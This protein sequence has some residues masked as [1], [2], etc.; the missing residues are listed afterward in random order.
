ML[1][2]CLLSGARFA[3]EVARAAW[4]SG[5]SVRAAVCAGEGAIFEDAS[6]QQSFATPASARAAQLLSRLRK[7]A[8]SALAIEGAGPL[9]LEQLRLRL[10]GWELEPGSE[11][12]PVI[13]RPV[14]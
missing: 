8:H 7:G 3:R 11:G 10:Q 5:L 6:E 4:E 9:L 13:F 12:E 2:E 1:D 14:K